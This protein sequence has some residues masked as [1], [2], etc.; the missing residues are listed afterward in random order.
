VQ[1]LGRPEEGVRSPG[2]RIRVGC[3]QLVV[4][5][6]QERVS[7]PLGLELQMVVSW[8]LS[9]V[10]WKSAVVLTDEPSLYLTCL[11]C[12]FT[13]LC[14]SVCGHAWAKNVHVCCR[15]C[16]SPPHQAVLEDRTQVLRFGGNHR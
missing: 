3:E 11:S 4:G 12:L 14:V 7:D 8:E 2:A 15:S 1:C 5:L 13:C 16:F 6:S 9:L 10:L